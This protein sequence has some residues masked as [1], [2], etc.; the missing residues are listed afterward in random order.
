MKHIGQI[1]S[2]LGIEGVHSE[3][4]MWRYKPKKKSE[5]GVQ[6]DLLID[7]QDLCINICEMKFSTTEFTIDKKYASELENKLN[8]FRRETQTKK[9]LLLTLITTYGIKDN[10][11]KQQLVDNEISMDV[12]FEKR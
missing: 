6:I 3:S 11:Y 12:L 4:S 7:R 8:V 1:K 5:Q 2:A 9:T 10:T